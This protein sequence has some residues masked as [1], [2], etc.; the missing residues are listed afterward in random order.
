MV[1]YSDGTYYILGHVVNDAI[2]HVT[3]EGVGHVTDDV[4]GHMVGILIE[5]TEAWGCRYSLYS[6][7]NNDMD[8]SCATSTGNF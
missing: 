1:G 6:S 3:D 8:S 2:G 5:M 7:G 4:T